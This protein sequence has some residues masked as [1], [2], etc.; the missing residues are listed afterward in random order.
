MTHLK[1]KSLKK[2]PFIEL[3]KAY[4]VAAITVFFVN[5]QF[6]I[7]KY[8]LLSKRREATLTDCL[9]QP[10]VELVVSLLRTSKGKRKGHLSLST[11]R[12]SVT[13][14]HQ[15]EYHL[16][17]TV[18]A[19][20]IPAVGNLSPSRGYFLATKLALYSFFLP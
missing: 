20:F 1:E 16:P 7:F 17:G 2:L 3:M 14:M 12:C 9:V 10:S 4:A 15:K 13:L 11:S 19:I 8:K 18:L 5:M 6:I